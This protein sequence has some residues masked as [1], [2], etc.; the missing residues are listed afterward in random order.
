MAVRRSRL[1]AVLQAALYW[2]RRAR[3]ERQED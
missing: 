3:L 2:M 1:R